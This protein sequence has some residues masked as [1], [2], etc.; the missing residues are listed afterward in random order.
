MPAKSAHERTARGGGC[1]GSIRP[2]VATREAAACAL[3]RTRFRPPAVR[4][5]V[6]GWLGECPSSARIRYV[7]PRAH[8][9]SE[10]PQSTPRGYPRVPAEYAVLPP[11]FTAGGVRLTAMRAARPT[12]SASNRIESVPR[13]R[14]N[15]VGQ[16]LRRIGRSSSHRTRGA[17]AAGVGRRGAAACLQ[18]RSAGLCDD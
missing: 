6:Q 2:A 18:Q 10:Y 7:Y 15:C 4:Y 1:C 9:S 12:A 8:P 11:P 16:H 17:P 5:V 3:A 13:A 14:P